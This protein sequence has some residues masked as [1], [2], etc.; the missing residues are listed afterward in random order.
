MLEREGDE[1]L[2]RYMNIILCKKIVTN[3]N[4]KDAAWWIIIKNT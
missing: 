3:F 2:Y 1:I 4:A